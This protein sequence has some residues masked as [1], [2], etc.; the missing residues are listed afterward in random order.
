MGEKEYHE[1]D[2]GFL[3][4]KMGIKPL[5]V[6][7]MGR[8]I[9]PWKDYRAYHKIT[10]IIKQFKPDIV[11]THAAKPGT[12]GRLAAHHMKVPVVVHTFHGHVFHSYFNKPKTQVFLNIERYLARKSTALIAISQEQK[13]ELVGQYRVAKENKF[14]IIPLGFQLERFMEDN[15]QKRKAF[16]EEFGLA[17]DEIAIG[18]TGR[19]VPVKNHDLF[20]EA[21]AYVL[22]N[23]TKKV[24]AFIVGD[25]TSNP[26]IQA[27]AVA[28]NIPY[29]LSGEPLQDRPLIFTSWR[30]DIDVVNAGLD[31]ACLTSLNEGTPVSLIEAQAAGRPVVSTDVGGV[32]DAII[33]HETGFLAPINN[34]QLLFDHLLTLINDDT[35]RNRMGKQGA[36][37]A[38]ER[39]GVRR[40]ASDFR[41]L[42]YSL[43]QK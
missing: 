43:L 2:A 21:L 29:C 20:L 12:V 30:S 16:R 1:Q 6:P 38:A 35:L 15:A 37:F 4:E 3:A 22:A 9:H 10:E 34:K 40:L 23:T 17:D 14:H 26:H 27:R 11:H 36:G 41:N 32:K 39:F 5:L 7:E 13:E 31:I 19:L 18:I 25:G 24:K 42:Y 33:E 8:S 28:L